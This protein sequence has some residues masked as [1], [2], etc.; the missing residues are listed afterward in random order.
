MKTNFLTLFVLRLLSQPLF[1]MMNNLSGSVT[2][3]L[4]PRCTCHTLF[5][6]VPSAEQASASKTG[7]AQSSWAYSSFLQRF[8]PLLWLSHSFQTCSKRRAS[9]RFRKWRH[10]L[11]KNVYAFFFQRSCSSMHLSHSIRYLACCLKL[12]RLLQRCCRWFLWLDGWQWCYQL[13]GRW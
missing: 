3:G 13:L 10:I 8:R 1:K 7:N 5:K 4:A 9:V 11:Y 12:D 2:N 6:P